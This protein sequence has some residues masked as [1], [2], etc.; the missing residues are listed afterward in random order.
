MSAQRIK[1]L[2]VFRGLAAMAVVLYHYTY[3]FKV[4]FPDTNYEAP[5][6]LNHFN[7]GIELFFIISGYVI[8]L[9]VDRNNQAR[10]FII[11]RFSRLF[12]A[13]WVSVMLAWGLAQTLNIPE[14]KTP[15]K[16]FLWN[17]TMFQSFPKI[18][19]LLVQK[20]YW[21]LGAE[22]CF[23][24]FV[25]AGLITGLYRKPLII[26]PGLMI[27]MLVVNFIY[28]HHGMPYYM[29]VY[30]YLFLY[31]SLPLFCFGILMYLFKKGES[32]YLVT[33]NI[34][35][36]MLAYAMVKDRAGIIAV[37]LFAI[38]ILLYIKG[39]LTW[40]VNPVTVFFGTISYSLYL[41]HQNL[42]YVLL[43]KL[44]GCGLNSNLALTI[45]IAVAILL[46]TLITYTIEKPGMRAIRSWLE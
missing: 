41:I 22:L 36:C 26:I 20:V 4:I 25:L 5:F 13:Y 35:L 37:S 10:H 27:L 15:F 31:N 28:L 9:T 29:P 11:S 39:W 18:H 32:K 34:L 7:L 44:S 30:Q 24:M 17:L 21:T 19:V 16:D 40:I 6:V 23:Y 2:D 42:G 33:V 12:P 46:A 1:E 43:L 38:M 14:L 8:Y 45:T 3:N